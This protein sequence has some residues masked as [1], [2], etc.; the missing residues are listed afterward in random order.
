MADMVTCSW[1]GDAMVVLGSKVKNRQVRV[2]I[3]KLRAP[4]E[5][6]V[7]DMDG[8]GRDDLVLADAEST[9]AYVYL[10]RDLPDQGGG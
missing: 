2:D 4:W 5:M 9:S 7:G 3:G 10:G 1:N 6:A 8:D